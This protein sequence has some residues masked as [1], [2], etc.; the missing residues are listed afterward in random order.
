[1]CLAA[2]GLSWTGCIPSPCC[3]TPVHQLTCF[4][5][6]AESVISPWIAIQVLQ[7]AAVFVKQFSSSP[8]QTYVLNQ[9]YSV[10]PFSLGRERTLPGLCGQRACAMEQ[11]SIYYLASATTNGVASLVIIQM[12]P[13]SVPVWSVV[14]QKVRDNANRERRRQ[15]LR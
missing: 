13:G 12:N 5:M 3:T 10:L 9:F 7:S 14:P 8:F 4:M 11:G 1:M 6:K 2:T 15:V